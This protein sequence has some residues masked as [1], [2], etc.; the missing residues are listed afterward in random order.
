MQRGHVVRH[1]GAVGEPEF[2]PVVVAE[3]EP[4]ILAVTEPEFIAEPEPQLIAN[5]FA[6]VLDVQWLRQS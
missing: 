2:I 6:A 1:A 5:S 4:V 3:L